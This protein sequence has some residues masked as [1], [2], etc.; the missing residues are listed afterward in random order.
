MCNKGFLYSSIL[1]LLVMPLFPPVLLSQNNNTQS[2]L[3]QNWQVFHDQGNYDKAIEQARLIY[4]LGSSTQNNE[5]MAQSL[6]WEGLST[7]KKTKRAASNRKSAARLFEKS[8]GLL[9]SLNNQ[10]LEIDNLTQL[11]EIARIDEDNQAFSSYDKRLKEIENQ[12]NI[13]QSN[14]DLSQKVEALG[15]Q[16]NQLQQRVQSLSAAQ[17]KAELMLA[18]QKN[19]LDS[20]E[21]VR[22]NDAFELEKK[23]LELTSQSA[24]LKLQDQ[25][26]QLQSSQR[27]FFIAIAAILTLLAIGIY[28]RFSEVKKYN[29]ALNAKNEALIAEQ[30]RSEM[31][32]LNIL[33]VMV[34]EEL[35]THGN[36]K[37][38]RY[39]QATVMFTDFKDFSKVANSL[40]PEQL[41]AELDVYFKGFDE[42]ISKYKIEK[43]KTI[44]DA[45]MCVGGLPETGGSQPQDVV[46]AALE[47]QEMLDRFKAE[48]QKTNKPFFE[49]RIGIH[50]GPLVAGVVGSKKFAY[51]IWGDTVNVAS[52]LETNGEPRKVNIS[53]STYELVKPYFQ[54][55][56]RGQIAIKNLDKVDM[57]FVNKRA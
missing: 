30:K 31:L 42:I 22:M 8:L 38:R 49:A 17:M 35:K 3:I 1:L 53:S 25:Q 36:T 19:Y 7:L 24:Q 45:Y 56:P 11:R 23:E 55:E 57:Y 16:A 51:D 12:I 27:N 32:L 48:R 43:I 39:D 9:T 44:G 34:A 46:A 6:Y 47:I 29:I 5:L 54:F 26:I 10:A 52:R 40:S 2:T 21:M 18:M 13:N 15:S 41:V 28:L 20:L 50:T 33:P 14:R 4:Q 37:A